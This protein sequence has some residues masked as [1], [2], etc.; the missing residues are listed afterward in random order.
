MGNLKVLRTYVLLKSDRPPR[1]GALVDPPR[2]PW[3]F[4]RAPGHTAGMDATRRPRTLKRRLEAES[5][6]CRRTVAC[7]ATSLLKPKLPVVTKRAVLAAKLRRHAMPSSCSSQPHVHESRQRL[8]SVNCG[9][10]QR[11]SR[12]RRIP[13]WTSMNMYTSRHRLEMKK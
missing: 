10:G 4:T 1:P 5:K 7:V 6:A 3:T 11:F 2:G 9:P 8:S 12:A 13:I